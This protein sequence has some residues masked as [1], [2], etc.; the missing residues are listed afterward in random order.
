MFT[1]PNYALNI[2]EI[3][4]QNFNAGRSVTREKEQSLVL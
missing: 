2:S 4:R 3:V 1:V